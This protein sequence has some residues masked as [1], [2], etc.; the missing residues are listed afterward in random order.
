[1][2][3][4]LKIF[5]LFL[6]L[7][8]Q[9]P[10]HSITYKQLN[11]AISLTFA[12]LIYKDKEITGSKLYSENNIINNLNSHIQ[13]LEANIIELGNTINPKFTA[14]K[15][16]QMHFKL[17]LYNFLKTVPFSLIFYKILNWLVEA[18]LKK[19]IA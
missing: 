16:K 3:K 11:A 7:Q 18:G 12:Y 9:K 10:I 6:L 19:E 1:M 2:N 4:Y 8:T 13:S 5:L 15:N 17:F 14:L